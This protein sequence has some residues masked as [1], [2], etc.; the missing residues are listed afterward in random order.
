MV[1][2]SGPLGEII[3]NVHDPRTIKNMAGWFEGIRHLFVMPEIKQRGKGKPHPAPFIG[4]GSPAPFT[5]YFTGHNAFMPVLFAIEKMQVIYPCG[6][7][8]MALMKDG[9]PLHGGAVQFLAE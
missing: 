3:V 7:S 9:G 4:N 1:L 6:E 2:V 8:H 5:R